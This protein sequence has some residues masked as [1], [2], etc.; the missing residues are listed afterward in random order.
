MI[1][2][3][4]MDMRVSRTEIKKSHERLQALAVPLANLSKKQ[5][6]SLPVSEYFLDELSQLASISSG[7]AKN[8]QIKRVG[9]LIVEEDRHAL[10]QALFECQF[11]PEQIAKIETWYARLKL[12]DES[13]IKQFVKQFN[14]SEFNSIYQLLLWIE[15]AKHLQDDELLAESLADFESYVKE[16]AILST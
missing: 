13:T 6:K 14:A 12:S 7:G 5:Q 1:D 10:T 3:S 2:W 4:K 16:V 11:T 8:R 15:Y 9:K